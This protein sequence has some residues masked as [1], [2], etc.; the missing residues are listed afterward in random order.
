MEQPTNEPAQNLSENLERCLNGD[1][2][3]FRPIVE[4]HQQY[5]FS[6]A[7]RMLSD[8]EEAND[9]V[10]DSFIRVWKNLSFYRPTM[11]FTTWLYTIVT[12]LCYD[13]LRARRRIR[14]RRLEEIDA[15][16]LASLASEHNPEQLYTN[17]ELVQTMSILTEELPHQQKFVFV[18]RDLEGFS[19]RE[20]SEML[21][22]SE[23]SVKTN[24]VYARR[25]LRQR[26][27]PF[28]SE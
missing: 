16:L 23:G 24:L 3:A 28:I 2:N 27:E 15:S 10:Q 6:I 18:L 9:V 7:L 21:N 17:K 5:V 8:E 22:V 4:E 13:K 1:M 12:R 11:K 19:V 25:Y 14:T 26:L 20:V